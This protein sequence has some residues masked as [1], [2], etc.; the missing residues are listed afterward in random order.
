MTVPT[1]V[2]H[3]KSTSRLFT[4]V[5]LAA[6]LSACAPFSG[7]TLP[8]SDNTETTI[9][10][11]PSYG[12]YSYR[13]NELGKLVQ[14]DVEGKV[15]VYTAD[16]NNSGNLTWRQR[17]DYFD[18]LITGPLGQG[19]LHIEGSPGLVI[20]TTP[21]EQTQASSVEQLFAEHFDWQFPMQE[22]RYWVRGIASPEHKAKLTY[23]ETGELASV[24]QAGWQVAFTGYTQVSGLP[25]P[26]KITITGEDI[27]LK[28]V[29]KNWANLY[30]FPRLNTGAND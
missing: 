22:I 23:N 29:L 7:I 2:K 26:D 17:R 8:G 11:I 4:G 13:A 15:A 16:K 9:S 19:H 27:K 28:L 14:W 21:E 30:P 10:D 12:P 24:E 1:K 25:M 20:A 3:L 18:L 6:L 5:V